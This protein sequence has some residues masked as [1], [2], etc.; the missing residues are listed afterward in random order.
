MFSPAVRAIQATGVPAGEPFHEQAEVRPVTARVDDQV[1][2]IR[3]KAVRMD[4]HAEL[5][6]EFAEHCEI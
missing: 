3:H 4:L 5:L 6:T 2:V 1:H